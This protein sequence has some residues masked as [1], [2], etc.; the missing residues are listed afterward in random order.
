V[1]EARKRPPSRG[2]T[3]EVALPWDDLRG[4]AVKEDGNTG[5][6]TV[7]PGARFRANL[8]RIEYQRPYDQPGFPHSYLT[9]APT[10]APLDFHRP[11]FFGTWELVEKLER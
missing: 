7:V 3:V 11:M 10:H 1:Q 6:H 2:Y 4:R 9:W 5:K 8:C